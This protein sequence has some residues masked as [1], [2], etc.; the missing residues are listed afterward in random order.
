MALSV[1]HAELQFATSIAACKVA[2]A[3]FM[4]AGG[5]DERMATGLAPNDRT[6]MPAGTLLTAES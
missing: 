1:L 2:I 5:S 3:T 6:L 4:G